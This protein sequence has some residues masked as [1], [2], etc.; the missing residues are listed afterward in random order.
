MPATE[1]QPQAPLTAP[2]TLYNGTGSPNGQGFSYLTSP[3]VNASATQVGSNLNTMPVKSDSAGFFAVSNV[4][5]LDRQVGYT[6]RFRVRLNAEDHAGS[7]KNRDGTED[8]A[9]FSVIILSSDKRGI[10]L[11]F[12]P[13]RVWAQNDG[14]AQPLPNSNTLFTQGEG[15]A[16]TTTADT[17][18]ELTI[19]GSTYTLRSGTT[20]IL[21]GPL[22]D[23]T[24]F[25][26]PPNTPNVYQIANFLFLGDDTSSARANVD[27]TGPIVLSPV[28]PSTAPAAYL[29]VIAQP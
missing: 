12:W 4:P 7:D 23:Y 14:A 5:T 19:Q 20:T 15:A 27:F 13:D 22:R 25:V 9:G 11:G 21:S 24:T 6:L 1:P 18:Y 29:P 8:R 26:S 17:A 3:L 28:A 2:V 10:E 16:F